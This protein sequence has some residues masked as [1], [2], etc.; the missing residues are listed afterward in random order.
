MRANVVVLTNESARLK[1][2]LG[3]TQPVLAV[4]VG[5]IARNHL[6]DLEFWCYTLAWTAC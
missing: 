1:G 4:E 6:V 2:D 3:N 5:Q